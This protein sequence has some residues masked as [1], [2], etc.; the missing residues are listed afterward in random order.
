MSSMSLRNRRVESSS[1]HDGSTGATTVSA[2]AISASARPPL[3]RAGG[4]DDQPVGMAGNVADVA[5]PC[6]S[7]GR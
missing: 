2:S 6:S 7:R 4:V 1:N 3:M 5:P